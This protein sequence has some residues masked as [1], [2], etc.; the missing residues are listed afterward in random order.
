MTNESLY[1]NFEINAN[2]AMYAQYGWTQEQFMRIVC[3]G[4]A[5]AMR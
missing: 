2:A 4:K 5:D 3:T 1:L